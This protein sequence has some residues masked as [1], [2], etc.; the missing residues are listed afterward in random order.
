MF[1]DGADALLGH[2]E[3]TERVFDLDV[4]TS[5]GMSVII[6]CVRV[7]LSHFLV[8]IGCGH[9]GLTSEGIFH[10]RNRIVLLWR[11]CSA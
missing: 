9:C 8:E 7:A 10:W 5:R 4:L 11:P 6:F 2:R 3:V 1:N